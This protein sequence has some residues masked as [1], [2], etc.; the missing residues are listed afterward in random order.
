MRSVSQ[1][2]DGRRLQPTQGTGEDGVSPTLLRREQRT[3][4]EK[5]NEM[6]SCCCV[7]CIVL[8]GEGDGDGGG[9]SVGSVGDNWC[10][11]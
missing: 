6:R 7:K 3:R 11:C 10:G 2:G 4:K 9:D 5:A 1:P 8:S